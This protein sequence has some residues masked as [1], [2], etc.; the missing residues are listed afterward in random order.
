MSTLTD[1]A[2]LK[3]TADAKDLAE[4]V[5]LAGTVAPAKSTRAVLQNLLLHGHDGVLEITGSDLEVSVRVRTDRVALASDGRMLVNAARLQQIL[6]ELSGE[7]VTLAADER[8]G[9]SVATGDARFQILGED[10]QDFPELADWPAEGGFRLPAGDLVDMIR[11]TQ[12]AAHAEKTRYAMNGLLVDIKGSRLHVVAT[13]GKRLALA[14]RALAFEVEQPLHVVVPTR[15][16][17][18]LQR[19]LAGAGG[20]VEV[21]VEPS[22]IHFRTASALVSA[23]LIQGHFPPYEDVLPKG[24]DKHLR[25]ASD[26]FHAALRR[27]ALLG[28]K[29]SLAVRFKFGR[30]GL[31]LTSRVPEVGESR[32]TFPVDFPYGDLEVGFNP[33]YFSDVLKVIDGAELHLELKDGRS[34]AIVRELGEDGPS[35][36][37]VYL[38]MPLSLAS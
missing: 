9:C 19:L 16:M 22:L 7:R 20:E 27:A 38:V 3:F 23:R 12:F 1:S 8:G 26:A 37:F 36:G 4:A 5:S 15:A 32:V 17:S 33:T 24:H 14:E 30:E 11:R 25:L 2:C 18:L 28:T 34:A 21:A 29:D 6:R 10:P 13:D 31:E 35:P